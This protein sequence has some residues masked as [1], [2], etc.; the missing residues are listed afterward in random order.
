MKKL[1]LLK[2]LL[3]LFW[4]FMIITMIAS[5]IFVPIIIFSTEPFDIPVRLN[6]E[7]VTI[8]DIPSKIL[9]LFVFAAF[10]SFF[11]SIYLLRELL[12]LFS[13]KQIFEERTILLLNRIGKC[14][15]LTSALTEIPSLIH[16]LI[17]SDVTEINFGG[18]FDSFLFTASLGLFFMVLSEVFRM[19]KTIKEENEL[20]V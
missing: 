11:Y 3:D 18:G 17:I 10:C 9:L 1:Y 20:T 19:G 15:L 16:N 6:G 13:K 4:V 12:T 14:F 5:I 2:S 8:V 7:K